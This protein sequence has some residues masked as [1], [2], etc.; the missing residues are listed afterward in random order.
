MTHLRWNDPT[1]TFTGVVN[2]SLFQCFSL[3]VKKKKDLCLLDQVLKM[4]TL[5]LNRS[6]NTK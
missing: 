2:D 3:F 1:Q 4:N 5:S 6:T